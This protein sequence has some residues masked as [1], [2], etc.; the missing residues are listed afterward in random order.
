MWNRYAREIKS[1]DTG[2][3]N[4]E[5]EVKTSKRAHLG[6]DRYKDASLPRYD[7]PILIYAGIRSLDANARDNR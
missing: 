7:A 3:D 5:T 2:G 1:V 4:E 6:I